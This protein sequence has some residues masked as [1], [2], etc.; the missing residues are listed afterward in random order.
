M[1]KHARCCWGEVILWE[2]DEA[3]ANNTDIDNIRASVAAAKKMK[4]GSITA[5][6]ERTGKGKQTFSARQHTYAETW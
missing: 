1:R 3:R 6:F 5:S 4:D 2:A